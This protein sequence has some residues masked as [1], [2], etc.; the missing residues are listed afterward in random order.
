[1]F[2][3]ALNCRDGFYE[4]NRILVIAEE[5]YLQEKFSDFQRAINVLKHGRGT[6]YDALVA[7]AGHLT[8]KGERVAGTLSAAIGGLLRDYRP[9]GLASP[10]QSPLHRAVP[11]PGSPR[12]H[13]RPRPSDPPT[14][15]AGTGVR[16]RVALNAGFPMEKRCLKK[17]RR[18][19][20]SSRLGSY[21]TL[22]QP[23]RRDCF[24]GQTF[25]HA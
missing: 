17:R 7:K 20:W 19:Q 15:P 11:W 4:A 18:G 24:C 12:R 22:R 16:D 9:V 2:Q 21:P 14:R 23:Q 25:T 5:T 6:S 10:Y 8:F 3:D 13:A 1:M